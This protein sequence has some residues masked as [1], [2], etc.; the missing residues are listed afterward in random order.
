[1]TDPEN[2]QPEPQEP[3]HTGP[4]GAPP[5]TGFLYKYQYWIIGTLCAAALLFEIVTSALAPTMSEELAQTGLRTFLEVA[6]NDNQKLAAALEELDKLG[7]HSQEDAYQYLYAQ[8]FPPAYTRYRKSIVISPA[9]P[10]E[11]TNRA[12]LE[13]MHI[14]QDKMPGFC[15][16]AL[17]PD[18]NFQTLPFDDV[19]QSVLD[20]LTSL[21]RR[22][23][24][25]M[26]DTIIQADQTPTQLGMTEEQAVAAHSMAFDRIVE[27]SGRQPLM[28]RAVDGKSTLADQCEL[29]T[30]AGEAV[31]TVPDYQR[32]VVLKGLLLAPFVEGGEP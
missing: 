29:I 4:V 7:K 11:E 10:L 8:V 12:N 32:I 5:D 31:D 23:F 27:Q 22:R 25:A 1:M 15:D 14:A 24:A 16:M 26:A 20:Q 9:A 13:I 2:P 6:Y 21:Q 30:L 18:I 17:V 28:Q 19:A 3:P